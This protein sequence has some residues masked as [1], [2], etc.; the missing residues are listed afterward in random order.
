MQGHTITFLSS[1]PDGETYVHPAPKQ[2]RCSVVQEGRGYHDIISWYLFQPWWYACR[3]VRCSNTPLEFL[4]CGWWIQTIRTIHKASFFQFQVF[5]LLLPQL[6]HSFCQTSCFPCVTFP[7]KGLSKDSTGGL[8]PGTV[9]DTCSLQS[10]QTG[11][12]KILTQ[13]TVV[14]IVEP[15]SS[16]TNLA[17]IA[18]QMAANLTEMDIAY[19]QNLSW[20]D[21]LVQ[22]I[23]LL[24]KHT[25]LWLSPV[26]A[27]NSR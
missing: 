17:A 10:V 3:T 19:I 9:F 26:R 4:A 25:S 23:S 22:T 27:I 8:W 5:F 11:P 15:K 13:M 7:T 18:V 24:Q 2:C 16:G 1:H 14:C 6:L 12:E 21:L 20:N